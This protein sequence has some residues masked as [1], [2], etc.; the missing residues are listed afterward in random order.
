MRK[1]Q[2]LSKTLSQVYCQVFT[3]NKSIFM[4]LPHRQPIHAILVNRTA[5]ETS[6]TGYSDT[7]VAMVT[8][9]VICIIS[10]VWYFI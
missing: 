1:T 5:L 3:E 7:A 2:I 10:R 4:P 8:Y 6:I 9:A